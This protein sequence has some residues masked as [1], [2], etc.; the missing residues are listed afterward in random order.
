MS[1]TDERKQERSGMRGGEGEEG[2]AI[3]NS[4]TDPRCQA[5]RTPEKGPETFLRLTFFPFVWISWSRTGF[6]QT[7]KPRGRR[8]TD[9]AL[10]E[11]K[12]LL[13]S[14]VREEIKDIPSKDQLP[15]NHILNEQCGESKLPR[16]LAPRRVGL[17]VHT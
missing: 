6:V 14:S 12:H 4:L 8:S 9:A 15:E 5:S 7:W 10:W 11:I 16:V 1:L 13:K 3:S 17:S 2:G